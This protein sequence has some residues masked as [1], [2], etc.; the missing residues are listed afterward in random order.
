M[1]RPQ[2]IL[3]NCGR[4]SFL[5]GRVLPKSQSFEE[6]GFQ[7][8]QPHPSKSVRTHLR[9]ASSMLNNLNGLKGTKDG[10]GLHRSQEQGLPPGQETRPSIDR[11]GRDSGVNLPGHRRCAAAVPNRAS[12]VLWRGPGGRADRSVLRCRWMADVL[13]YLG[14]SLLHESR[15]CLPCIVRDPLR[16]VGPQCGRLSS[17][18]LWTQRCRLKLT[19]TSNTRGRF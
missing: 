1:S 4:G 8:K 7:R 9:F 15:R 5:H 18:L 16:P 11:L 12:S 10:T 2:E 6:P 13:G 3:S 14:S 19:P 17:C